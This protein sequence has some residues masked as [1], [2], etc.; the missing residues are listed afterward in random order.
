M[1]KNSDFPTTAVLD[2]CIYGGKTASVGIKD[3]DK[4][5]V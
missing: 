5:G 1:V 2:K 4:V 3:D